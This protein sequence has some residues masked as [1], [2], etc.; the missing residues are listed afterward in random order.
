MINSFKGRIMGPLEPESFHLWATIGHED[1]VGV[2]FE[3]GRVT[4]LHWPSWALLGQQ[5]LSLTHFLFCYL[6]DSNVRELKGG[7]RG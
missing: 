1:R 6:H 4:E 7:I 3:Q 2:C 5:P